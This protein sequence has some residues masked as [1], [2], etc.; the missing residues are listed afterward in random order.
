MPLSSHSLV[1]KKRRSAKAAI[2]LP[3]SDRV[4]LRATGYYDDLAGFI[5]SHYPGRPVREG[6]NSAQRISKTDQSI[7]SANFTSGCLRLISSARGC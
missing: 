1:T 3:I 7:N 2:N 4:A 5:D 6:K